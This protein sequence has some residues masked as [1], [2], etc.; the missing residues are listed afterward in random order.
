MAKEK[1][2]AEGGGKDVQSN[3]VKGFPGGVRDSS[4]PGAEEHEHFARAAETSSAVGAV[5]SAKGPRMEGRGRGC[6][7]EK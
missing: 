1:H 2:G 6:C 5:Q 3:T 7:G 4:G